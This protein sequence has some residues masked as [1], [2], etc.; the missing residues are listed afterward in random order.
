[1]S[2]LYTITNINETTESIQILLTVENGMY[3]YSTEDGQSY[4]L[5]APLQTKEEFAFLLAMFGIS[6]IY[7][8]YDIYGH[9]KENTASFNLIQE[10]L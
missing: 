4:S 3:V 5:P 10:T 8:H 2:I 9:E 7:T 1:M 6:L